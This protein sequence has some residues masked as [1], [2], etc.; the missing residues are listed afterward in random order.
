MLRQTNF[1]ANVEG[2]FNYQVQNNTDDTHTRDFFYRVA[3]DV[4][5][6]LGSRTVISEK[7]P[8]FFPRFD[9][10][11]FRLRA[12]TTLSYNVWR[13]VYWNFTVRDSYDTTPAAK[14]QGNELE[15]HSSLGVKF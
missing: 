6:K 2:G 8:E 11:E 14:V 3:E 4:I 5:W 13:Y 15:I 12:E 9:F 10:S 7:V 1:V